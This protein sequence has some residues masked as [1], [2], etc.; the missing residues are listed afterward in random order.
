MLFGKLSFKFTTEKHAIPVKQCIMVL[1]NISIPVAQQ[2]LFAILRVPRITV[3][4]T[5]IEVVEHQNQ[6]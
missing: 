3:M 4:M 2:L 1:L 6:P 5:Y